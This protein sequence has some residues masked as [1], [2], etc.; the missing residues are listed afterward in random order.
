MMV[1][2]VRGEGGLQGANDWADD[3]GGVQKRARLRAL[4]QPPR[5]DGR[6]AWT[7]SNVW[8]PGATNKKAD[9]KAEQMGP[10]KSLWAHPRLSRRSPTDPPCMRGP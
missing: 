7:Q 10:Q 8:R 1:G 5:K 2:C 6:H 4:E 9:R 3:V